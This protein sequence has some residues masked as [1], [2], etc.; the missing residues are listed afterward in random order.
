MASAIRLPTMSS[1]FLIACRCARRNRQVEQL[2]GRLVDREAQP[3]VGGVGE[4]HRQ[5]DREHERQ[6]A[7]ERERQRQDQDD[8][9][10]AEPASAASPVS[11]SC[12]TNAGRPA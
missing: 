9:R 3:L 10:D 1:A 5:E 4:Q 8:R 12:R 2:V 11:S 7:A 6:R